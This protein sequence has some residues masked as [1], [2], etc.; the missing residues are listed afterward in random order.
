MN[1]YL[2]AAMA[3]QLVDA[4]SISLSDYVVLV[5]L[6]D[7]PNAELR[8]FELAEFLGWEKSRLSHHL[9]RMQRRRLISRRPCPDD[10]RGA[11]VAAT[12]EGV[13]AIEAAAPGHVEMVRQT[14]IDRLTTDQLHALSAISSIV[15]EG[16]GR[17]AI[18]RGMY[19]EST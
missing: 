12:L 7:V 4:S 14:V 15:L 13:A 19:E 1:R 6:T 8:Q 9:A 18:A 2:D 17:T 10:R 5:A 16:A 11:L 3:R